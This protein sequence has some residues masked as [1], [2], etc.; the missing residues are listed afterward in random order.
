MISEYRLGCVFE[1]LVPRA[2]C[3]V[4]VLTLEKNSAPGL[5]VAGDRSSSI[6]HLETPLQTC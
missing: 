4:I 6:S 5:V 1:E 3:L 2:S